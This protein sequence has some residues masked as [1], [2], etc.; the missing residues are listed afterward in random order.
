IALVGA[1][2][3]V[4]TGCAVSLGRVTQARAAA[5]RDDRVKFFEFRPRTDAFGTLTQ[6]T[7]A[8][9]KEM[10]ERWSNPNIQIEM[11]LSL[12]VFLPGAIYLAGLARRRAR[13]FDANRAIQRAAFALT[14]LAIAGPLL[15]H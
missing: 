12:A 2:W 13:G 14:V 4:S 9:L 3:I 6:S 1:V 8:S 11:G 15:L 10:R 5:L 7:D